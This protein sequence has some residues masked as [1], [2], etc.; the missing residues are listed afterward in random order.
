MLQRQNKCKALR[1]ER[2]RRKIGYE[3]FPMFWNQKRTICSFVM[4][5]IL[6]LLIITFFIFFLHLAFL[7]HKI[8]TYSSLLYT[9]CAS[10]TMPHHLALAVESWLAVPIELSADHKLRTIKGKVVPYSLPSIGPRVDPGIQAGCRRWLCKSYPGGR[11]PLLSAS[12][13]VSQPKNVIV[14]WLVPSY[15]AWWQT[16]RC[17]QLDQCC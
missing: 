4:I 13:A 1:Q 8:L 3:A 12:P 5:T 2:M 10:D 7:H 17:E 14:L 15:T 16:H 11:L 6:L 9:T